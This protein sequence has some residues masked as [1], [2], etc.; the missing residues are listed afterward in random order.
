MSNIASVPTKVA[1]VTWTA[2]NKRVIEYFYDIE[3]DD[4]VMFKCSRICNTGVV[5]KIEWFKIEKATLESY[6]DYE[7]EFKIGGEDDDDINYAGG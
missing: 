4:K 7:P 3:N 6:K 2:Y 5:H 1:R